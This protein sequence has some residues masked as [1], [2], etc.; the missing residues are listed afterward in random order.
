VARSVCKRGLSLA[1][2]DEE[3]YQ[4]E[5]RCGAPMRLRS[6][7]NSLRP[8]VEEPA[9]SDPP[10]FLRRFPGAYCALVSSIAIAPLP[11]MRFCRSS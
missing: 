8:K 7:G 4:A 5:H 1:L 3:E 6:R 11:A 9:G 2:G 10:S